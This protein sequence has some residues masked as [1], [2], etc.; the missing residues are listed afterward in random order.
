MDL[1]VFERLSTQKG[2]FALYS[3]RFLALAEE[4]PIKSE[5]GVLY[6]RP[7]MMALSNLLH[8]PRIGPELINGSDSWKRSNKDLGRVLALAW[9]A[10]DREPEALSD[11]P[12]CWRVALEKR[13]PDEW[14][15]LASNCGSGLRALVQSS[16]ELRQ[17][18]QI[19]N[20]SLLAGK[21]VDAAALRS[22]ALRVIGDAIS[23]LEKAARE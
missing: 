13:F 6:A 14:R 23:P 21:D 8:H 11:W 22:T 4:K 5:F 3:F 10:L 17:A 2:D 20:L 19:C 7:E 9:L 18:T 15:K 1:K 16:I 12:D